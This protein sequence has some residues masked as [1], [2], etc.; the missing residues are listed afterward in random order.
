MQLTSCSSVESC[1]KIQKFEL[2]LFD[3]ARIHWARCRKNRELYEH[4]E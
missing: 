4:A 2:E 3:R 1:K